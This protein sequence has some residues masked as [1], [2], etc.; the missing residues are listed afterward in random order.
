MRQNRP[1]EALSQCEKSLALLKDCNKP[2]KMCA[3]YKDMATI[4]QNRNHLDR[5]LDY[6]SMVRKLALVP[7]RTLPTFVMS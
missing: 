3:V 7:F 2:E 4:E 5:A 1:E 6:L